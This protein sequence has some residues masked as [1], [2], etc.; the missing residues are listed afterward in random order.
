MKIRNRYKFIIMYQALPMKTGKARQIN[1]KLEKDLKKLV[2]LCGYRFIGSG[3][4]FTNKRR[5]MEFE[6]NV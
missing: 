6:A 2:K 4:D 5:D 1:K 3:Y